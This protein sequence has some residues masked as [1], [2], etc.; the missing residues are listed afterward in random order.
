MYGETDAQ[1]INGS[2]HMRHLMYMFDVAIQ[3]R[4]RKMYALQSLEQSPEE[5]QQHASLGE[6]DEEQ[7]QITRAI[8]NMLPKNLMSLAHPCKYITADGDFG[9]LLSHSPCARRRWDGDML[10]AIRER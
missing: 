9:G 1:G 2:I 4:C 8:A 6:D 10:F 3:I 5:D 7:E